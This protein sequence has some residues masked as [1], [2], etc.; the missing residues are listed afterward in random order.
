MA[1]ILDQRD[2]VERFNGHV[3]VDDPERYL[4]CAGVLSGKQEPDAREITSMLVVNYVHVVR[5]C[6]CIL[7][8]NPFARICIIGSESGIS[9]SFDKIYA[10]SKAAI[11]SYIET[12]RVGPHQQL[13]GIAPSIIEDAGMTLRRTDTENLERRWKS[14][15]KQRFLKSEEVAELVVFLLY[16]DRGY[17]CNTVIR[18]NGG[19]H[20]R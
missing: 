4:F 3:N 11:H 7:S 13:V 19:D 15:P 16:Q 14:H 5:A 10:G 17:I 6:E 9:G 2:T 1:R 8:A 12:R 18:M 20:A